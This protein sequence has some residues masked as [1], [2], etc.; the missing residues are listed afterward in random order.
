MPLAARL[1]LPAYGDEVVIMVKSIAA[2]SVMTLMDVTGIAH[3]LISETFRAFEVFACAGTIYLSFNAAIAWV[4]YQAERWLA[5]PS[6]Q[7]KSVERTA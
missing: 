1:A 2:A 4:V 7:R 3:G 5:V 6:L